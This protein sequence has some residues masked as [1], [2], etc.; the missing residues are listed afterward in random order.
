VPK[1]GPFSAFGL[2][3]PT[4]D[5]QRLFMAS[6]NATL[7]RYRELLV[8]AGAGRLHLENF[9][10]DTGKPTAPADYRLADEAYSKLARTLVE[11]GAAPPAPLRDDLLAFFADPAKPI[12]TRRNRRVWNDTMEAVGQL[13][14]RR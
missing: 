13:Q 4:P 8:E 2:R 9:N 14:T 6:F 3:P 11:K 12:A 5:T 10:L 7:T 1:V